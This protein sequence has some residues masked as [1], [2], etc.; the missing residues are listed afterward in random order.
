MHHNQTAASLELR[1]LLQDGDQVS[2]VAD[3]S[4][5]LRVTSR[6]KRVKLTIL[7]LICMNEK[8]K[9]WR[10]RTFDQTIH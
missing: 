5:A 4:E 2:G 8:Q 7:S 10:T 1:L 9:L 3:I 6:K